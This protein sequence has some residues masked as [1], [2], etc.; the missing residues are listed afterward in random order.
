MDRFII[1]FLAGIFVIGAVMFALISRSHKGRHSLNVEHFRTKCLEIEH[2]LKNDDKSSYHLCVLNADKLLDE[3]LKCRGAKG[4][5]FGERLKN[6]KE[7]FSDLNGVWTAHK[8]RN[9]IAHE[10][11]VQVSYSQARTALQQ[12]RR[13]LKDLGAI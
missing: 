13:A 12:F 4:A 10:S 3:A 8:L 9:Q 5:S 11:G 2:Q 1:F 6:S 7:L